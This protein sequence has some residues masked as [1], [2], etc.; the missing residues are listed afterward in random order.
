MITFFKRGYPER[1][2]RAVEI[3][4]AGLFWGDS[5]NRIGCYTFVNEGSQVFQI[6][7]IKGNAEFAQFT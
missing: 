2:G 7:Y 1:D 4:E 5:I 3:E 6:W